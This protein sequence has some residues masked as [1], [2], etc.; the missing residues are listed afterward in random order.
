MSSILEG[1]RIHTNDLQLG[2]LLHIEFFFI[3]TQSIRKC[4]AILLIADAKSR[5]V[6]KFSTPGKTSPTSTLHFFLTQL[7]IVGHYTM[8]I[9]IYM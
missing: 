1:R 8:S 9:R 6:W 2:E 3:G 7:K 5:S 4:F